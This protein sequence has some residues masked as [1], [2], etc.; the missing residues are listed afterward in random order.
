MTKEVGDTVAFGDTDPLEE[1]MGVRCEDMSP[2]QLVSYIKSY[3]EA[4]GL[5]IR[6]DGHP[7]RGV[8]RGMLRIYG[9]RDT[10]LIVK[11][12][13]YKHKGRREDGTPV[14]PLSFA[15]GR[16]WWVD[17][18]HLEMQQEQHRSAPMSYTAAAA[19]FGVRSLSDL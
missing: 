17:K 13:F 12:V 1:D 2:D 5:T 15:K 3:Q 16:K 9:Q 7:E 10:G 19:A 6:I 11:W 18:M 4:F 8:F 14:T